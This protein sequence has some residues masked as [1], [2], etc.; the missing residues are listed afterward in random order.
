[1]DAVTYPDPA[2][3][4]ELERWIGSRIDVAERPRV[5]GAFDVPAVPVA[6]ALDG[7]GAVLGRLPGFVAPAGLAAWLREIRARSAERATSPR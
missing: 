6:L 5:A 2:V 3:R 4:A 7:E 1:M